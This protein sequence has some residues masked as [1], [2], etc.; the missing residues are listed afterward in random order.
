MPLEEEM[1]HEMR[2]LEKE[3]MLID[4]EL[5]KLHSQI[6]HLIAIRKKKEHDLRILRQN[7]GEENDAAQIQTTLAKLLREKV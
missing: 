7:F 1:R 4:D 3:I 6:L 5:E 2:K